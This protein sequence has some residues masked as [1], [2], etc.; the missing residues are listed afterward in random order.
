M[1]YFFKFFRKIETLSTDIKK[2]L[3]YSIWIVTIL[4]HY[5]Y[6]VFFVLLWIIKFLTKKIRD[7]D[8][9][10]KLPRIKDYKTPIYNLSF[11][12]P[13]LYQIFIAITYIIIRIYTIILP[14]ILNYIIKIVFWINLSLWFVI[15]IVI[16]LWIL[17]YF[18][19]NKAIRFICSINKNEIIPFYL[20]NIP[21]KLKKIFLTDDDYI[22]EDDDEDED[23][24]EMQKQ[25]IK[26]FD[27][28]AFKNLEERFWSWMRNKDREEDDDEDNY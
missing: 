12:I 25:K 9:Y 23:D 4:F 3:Y 1:K 13:F 17:F 21:E 15:P 10:Y 14:I 16:S 27:L 5:Y 11:Q 7:N 24:F 28:W 26:D 22:R 20:I 2:F 6:L 8:K 18:L 19:W